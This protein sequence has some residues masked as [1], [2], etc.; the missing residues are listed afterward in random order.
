MFT[1]STIKPNQEEMERR[2]NEDKAIFEQNVMQGNEE[3][4]QQV[5]TLITTNTLSKG[6]LEDCEELLNYI[7]VNKA[8]MAIIKSAI[9][10]G[11]LT[12]CGGVGR[13]V[14]SLTKE[15]ED[16]YVKEL[17]EI[18]QGHS[19]ISNTFA[20]IKNYKYFKNSES[21]MD[22][23]EKLISKYG[24]NNA[25]HREIM[26]RRRDDFNAKH[27]KGLEELSK[28]ELVALKAQLEAKLAKVEELL[29][30]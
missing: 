24:I 7:E 18:A 4:F 8:S 21:F 22:D 6:K 5:Q 30:K 3:F 14:V 10:Y 1:K 12:T 27:G 13:V 15:Q 9:K 29:N 17:K 16:A 2:F 26:D 28:D 19:E 20:N 11:F 25:R 23:V